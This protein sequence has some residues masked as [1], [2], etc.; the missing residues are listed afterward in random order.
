MKTK[1]HGVRCIKISGEYIRLDT[2]L[3]LASVASTGGE[4]KVL[5]QCGMVF[6]GGEMCTMR[7]KKIR[8]GDVVRHGKESLLVEYET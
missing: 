7:G 4:A 2:L 3:K 6:V 1:L 8:P 5:I